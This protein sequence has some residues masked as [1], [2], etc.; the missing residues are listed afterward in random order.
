[1]V[2]Y[3]CTKQ[4]GKK[5]AGFTDGGTVASS[6]LLGDWYVNRLN[7]GTERLLL[8]V[9][10]PTLLAIIIPAKDLPAFPDRLK[11]GLAGML[12]LLDV[13]AN[14]IEREIL[15]MH[16]CRF[17]PTASRTVLGSMNDFVGHIEFHRSR[18][19]NSI[20]WQ[21]RIAEMPCSPLGYENPGTA[22]RKFFGIPGHWMTVTR[23]LFS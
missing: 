13:S 21:L 16:E 12:R 5:L 23:R 9:S 20:D 7:L 15:E 19:T 10:E 14:D 22:A 11:A 17:A 4:V 2:T 6:N 8:C 18:T 1:M 3:R